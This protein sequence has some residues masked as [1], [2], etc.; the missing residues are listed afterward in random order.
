MERPTFHYCPEKNWMNDPNGLCQV[1]G[2]YHLYYQYNPH[3]SV[4]GDMHWGHARSRDMMAWETLPVAMAPDEAAGEIHC[5][6]GS[7]CK[8]DAGQ[9][10]FF[11]TSIGREEAGRGC[12]D[13]AQQWTAEPRDGM[14]RLVQTP[15]HAILQEIHGGAQVRD[16]RDPYVIPWQGGYLMAL[17]GCLAGR[18]CVLAYT[19]PD[20]RAWTYRGVVAQ[21][22]EADDVPWECPNLFALEGKMV[23]L[24]SPCAAPRY[25]VGTLGADFRLRVEHEGV[26]DPGGRQG[27][28]APQAFRDE[29]GRQILLGWMPET[30]GEAADIRK[31]WAGAMS[32]PRLLSLSAGGDL[33]AT[34]WPALADRLGQ[35][36]PVAEGAELV[37]GLVRMRWQAGE[38]PLRVTLLA[39]P[40]GAEATVLTLDAAGLLT[41]DRSRSSMDA[42]AGREAIARS[43]PMVGGA[44]EVLVVVDAS[45]VEC[46]VNGAWLSSRV[47]PTRDDARRLIIHD[48]AVRKGAGMLEIE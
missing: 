41:L 35:T 5:F 25:M 11:Y 47:Y 9:P 30:D 46:C 48:E 18:G 21:A 13:G 16:W 22:A 26:L 43:V 17:G 12:V 33:R 28:Y 1:D 39:T 42:E 10:H 45:T 6:S 2:W 29:G 15:R 31:G 44:A 34:L 40:D 37:H 19:S 4:W 20:L 3:G 7:C 14:N 24:Y 36:A 23:L 27:Y 8:D 32:L 38:K